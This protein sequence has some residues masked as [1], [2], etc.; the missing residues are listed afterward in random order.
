MPLYCI[1]W[2]IYDP[3]KTIAIQSLKHL[4]IPASP[5]KTTW[6]NHSVFHC[7]VST[8]NESLCCRSYWY[9]FALFFRQHIKRKNRALYHYRWCCLSSLEHASAKAVLL[10]WKKLLNELTLNMIPIASQQT[11]TVMDNTGN[12]AVIECN[13]R[14]V[15]VIKPTERDCFVGAANGFVSPKMIEY[16]SHTIDDWHSSERYYWK[17]G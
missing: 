14:H 17:P 1:D 12:F 11:L 2:Y 13:C 6:G 4:C 15:E 3:R 9:F 8:G 5:Q 7:N 16:N 10:S